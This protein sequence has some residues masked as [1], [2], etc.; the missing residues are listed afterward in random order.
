MAKRQRQLTKAEAIA[1]QEMA[2]AAAK[3]QRAKERADRLVLWN[4]IYREA[5]N[6]LP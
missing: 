4:N 1:Y 5:I 6:S 2:F 3:L